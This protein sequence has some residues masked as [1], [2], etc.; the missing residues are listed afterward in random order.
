MKITIISSAGHW[1]NGWAFKPEIIKDITDSF[2]RNGIQVDAY[3]VAELH[4]L[5]ILLEAHDPTNLILPNAYHVNRFRNSKELV[6]L[7]DV[8]DYYQL[9]TI[10]SGRQTLQNILQKDICQGILKTHAIPIP[11]F[12]VIR[13]SD[14][15]KEKTLLENSRL[16]FP[17]L[18]KPTDLAGSIGLSQDSIVYNQKEAI[19]Q[20]RTLFRNYQTNVIV[21]EFLQGDDITVAYFP[22]NDQTSKL[23]C[24][25]FKILTHSGT[26]AIIGRKEQ[27]RKW[28]DT[29]VMVPVEDEAILKQVKKIVPK[30]AK[31]L[32][33]KDITRVDGRL[34]KN[35]QFCV[36]D[37]N[38]FPGLDPNG[39]IQTVQCKTCFPNYPEEVVYDALL[40]TIILSAAHRYGMSVPRAV[41]KHNFFTLES[42]I[43]IQTEI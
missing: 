32:D 36:F 8:F 14:I 29:K 22:G 39:S 3:E 19:T 11:N 12:I 2:K 18:V 37:V 35:G 42:A 13:Q 17:V 23:L 30:I 1:E 4:E 41:A 31:I 28:D 7:G 27:E 38:G 16:N 40:N 20:I 9:P 34:D 5:E 15:G 6:W 43:T 33:I 24:T 26:N 10:G 21:E 25:Y